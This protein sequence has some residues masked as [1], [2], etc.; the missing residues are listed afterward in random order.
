MLAFALIF[1]LVQF[2]VTTVFATDLLPVVKVKADFK[3][4]A[5]KSGNQISASI[6]EV[7]DAANSKG[8]WTFQVD[9]KVVATQENKGTTTTY[10]VKNSDKDQVVK[11]SFSGTVDE[12]TVVGSTEIKIPGTKLNTTNPT[13]PSNPS[14]QAGKV[15][16]DADLQVTV[17]DETEELIVLLDAKLK[18]AKKANGTWTVYLDNKKL[19]DVKNSKTTLS[20]E[21]P[22]E[23][24][25]PYNV[26]VEYKGTVDGKQVTGSTDVKVPAI[27]LEY[28]AVN[29]K[30]QF[31]ANIMNAEKVE[32]GVWWIGVGSGE[33][34]I[35]EHEAVQNTLSFSHTFDKLK[36][37]KYEVVVVFVG[38]VD[39]KETALGQYLEF[40][41]K[42]DGT[43]TPKPPVKEP[44]KPKPPVLNPEDA[45]KIVK[46]TKPGGPMP[47]TAT[48][49]PVSVLA[50]MALLALGAVLVRF[51]RAS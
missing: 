35:A 25:K 24:L 36:P 11:I 51:R 42:A 7:K 40:E 6:E 27:N 23:D 13:T 45:K 21:L 3:A 18:G 22:L 31:N 41:V 4:T 1:T 5:D 46:E 14:E 8:T 38:L 16:I 43:A 12:K 37:G 32:E 29:G 10:E 15:E 44:G 17:D 48:S 50:G 34:L 2:N 20:Y 19:G 9:G 47:K 28:K 33:E 39:G 30:H 49:Y 26:K